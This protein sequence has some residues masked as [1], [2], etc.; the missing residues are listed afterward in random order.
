MKENN[1]ASNQFE[2]KMRDKLNAE[3]NNCSSRILKLKI[4][5]PENKEGL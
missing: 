4:N 5:A 1:E 3:V 2:E